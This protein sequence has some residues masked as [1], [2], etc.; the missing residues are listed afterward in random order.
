[1][2]VRP[3]LRREKALLREG[4]TL[5]AGCDEV[6][7]GALAG[8]VT[9]GVVVV[10]QQ[11]RRVPVGLADSKLLSPARRQAMVPAIER[12]CLD[13]AVGHA[14]PSEIDRWGLTAALRL[15]GLRALAQL[16]STPDLVVLDGS[17]DWLTPTDREPELPGLWESWGSGD[18][19]QRFPE[20]PEPP[21][22]TVPRV[23][24]QVKAD[25]TC[26][27]VAAA[28][29]LAKT[30]RDALM[31]EL[32]GSHPYYAWDENKGYASPVHRR[33][34]RRRGPSIH[35]RTSWRLGLDDGLADDATSGLTGGASSVEVAS[36][37]GEVG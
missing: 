13:H 24:T 4:C 10:D 12:W 21:D 27:S 30:T 14:A 34:L 8:P 35:H 26:A 6:G 37:T 3:S 28:S 29:V 19:G 15:A 32:A 36:M 17:H 1:M 18:S 11:V 31:S 9:V 7:R 23:V 20:A 16:T 5:V 33:E 2:T 25:R 22:V